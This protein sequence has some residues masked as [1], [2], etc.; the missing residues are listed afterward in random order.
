MSLNLYPT[1]QREVQKIVSEEMKSLRENHHRI[2]AHREFE[3]RVSHRLQKMGLIAIV[4]TDPTD[5]FNYDLIG[6]DETL[7]YIPRVDVL[8]RVGGDVETDFDRMQH[9]TKKEAGY[10]VLSDGSKREYK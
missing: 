7:V 9:E 5:P 8:S 6:D 1:E 2:N 4:S 10:E 3:S